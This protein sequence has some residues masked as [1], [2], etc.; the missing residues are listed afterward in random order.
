VARAIVRKYPELKV[1]LTQDR[2]WKERF[3]ANMFDAV[4]LGM[5]VSSQK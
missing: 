2:A 1:Y 5:M 4:A 3:H